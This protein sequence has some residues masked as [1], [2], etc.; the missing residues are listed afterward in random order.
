MSKPISDHI[1]CKIMIGSHIPKY[2]IFIF[3]NF[4]SDH[5]RFTDTV[6]ESWLSPR[7][8][9]NNSAATLSLKRKNLRHSLKNW[10]KSL[11][12]LTALSD[13]CNKVI[14]F[15]DSLKECRSLF[16]LEW[17]FR[18]IIKA[19]LLQLLRYMNIYWK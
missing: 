13:F 3:E 4:W 16:L 2:R 17:N 10:S 6:K 5:P 14:F 15:M 19:K 11:S 12:K 9:R 8:T 18:T 1:S 7:Q